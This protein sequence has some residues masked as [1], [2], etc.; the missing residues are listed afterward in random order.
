MYKTAM[1]HKMGGIKGRRERASIHDGPSR[2][3]LVLPSYAC[4]CYDMMRPLHLLVY[5]VR[6]TSKII[7]PEASISK[8]P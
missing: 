1:P 7:V 3:M 5:T 6:F 8:M 2:N 4:I